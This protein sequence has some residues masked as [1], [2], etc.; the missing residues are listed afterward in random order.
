MNKKTLPPK[1][2]LPLSALSAVF[3]G[4][5]AWYVYDPGDSGTSVIMAAMSA[6]NLWMLVRFRLVFKRYASNQK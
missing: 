5:L 1:F 6:L 3:W 2:V 4:V